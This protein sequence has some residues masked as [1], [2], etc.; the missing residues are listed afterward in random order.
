MI[1]GVVIGAIG[2]AVYHSESV[3]NTKK[4]NNYQS[5][6]CYLDPQYQSYEDAMAGDLFTNL[7]LFTADNAL[8]DPNVKIVR[9]PDPNTPYRVLENALDWNNQL[10]ERNA[11]LAKESYF[12][13]PGRNRKPLSVP[14]YQNKPVLTMLKSAEQ[15]PGA[16]EQFSIFTK[17][18]YPQGESP[19]GVPSTINPRNYR[20]ILGSY[21]PFNMPKDTITSITALGNPWGPGGVIGR[22]M[23]Q[24]GD[25]L[26]SQYDYIDQSRP[27]SQHATV[28][29][30][31]F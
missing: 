30:D 28:Y 23:I 14:Q 27:G 17:L 1:L 3:K 5:Q 6:T 12:A 9:S 21:T 25:R 26:D 31:Q 11:S 20:D 18:E 2:L 13:L 19:Q 10:R 29:P 16:K 7:G 22:A 8:D 4:R 24:G 15:F